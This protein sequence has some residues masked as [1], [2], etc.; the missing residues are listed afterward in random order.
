MN[1]KESTLKTQEGIKMPVNTDDFLSVEEVAELLKS[2]P[3]T[4]YTYT[5][6]SGVNK[7]KKRA[8]F[9]KDTYIKLGRK[10]LFIK[11][12]LMNWL[13]SGA[14]MDKPGGGN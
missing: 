9:P 6:N 12:K 5:C 14:Q 1:K 13:L 8:H 3:G 7:G 2:T 4:I 10:V 11:E